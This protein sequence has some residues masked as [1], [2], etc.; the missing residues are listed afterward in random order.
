MQKAFHEGIFR[1]A[2]C[3]FFEKHLCFSSFFEW[4][5]FSRAKLIR[6][7]SGTAAN[8]RSELPRSEEKTGLNIHRQSYVG[9]VI[10]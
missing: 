1:G 4:V 10:A 7:A 3:I 2:Y 8:R 5:C 6:K 9:K